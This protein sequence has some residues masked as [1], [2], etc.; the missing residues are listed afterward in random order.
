[1]YAKIEF[2][3]IAYLCSTIEIMEHKNIYDLARSEFSNVRIPMDISDY[4][5]EKDTRLLIPFSYDQHYGMMNKSGEVVVEPKFDL[6]LDSCRDDTDV[7]RVG[8]YYTYG[9]NR[10]T[11]EPSTYLRTKWGLLNSK[12]KFI[13]EPEYKQIGVSNDNRILTIQ[14][15]DGQ[16]EVIGVDG[17]VI[18]PKGTYP[19]IDSY[20]CG[21]ARVYIG[22]CEN[23][24]W[25]II[26]AHG[27]IILPLKYS[28]IW[29]FY[30]KKRNDTTIEVCDEFGCKRMGRFNLI[31]YEVNIRYAGE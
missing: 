15:M 1:M 2:A 8:I 17:E 22:N 13:L 29:N 19:W 18:I 21:L 14:H 3:L 24:K 20:D 31:T 16:Y 4:E 28:N 10:E 30:K 7:V 11:K 23:K 26:D 9:F 6:I 25:G 27:N 5:I 12:G